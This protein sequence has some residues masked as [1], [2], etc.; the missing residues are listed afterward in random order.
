MKAFSGAGTPADLMIDLSVVSTMYGSEASI[1]EFCGRVTA[2]AAQVTSRYEIVL[3]ND[4]SPD[5]SCAIAHDLAASDPH[6]RVVDLSRNF[7]HHKAMMTGLAYAH[8]QRVFLIDSDLEED[9]AL[10]LAFW[11]QLDALDG[12]DV[13]YGYQTQRRGA[14]FERWTGALF[15]QLFTTATR[16]KVA[17]NLSTVRLMTRRYVDALIRYQESEFFFAGIAETVGFRQVPL[18]ITKLHRSQTTYSIVKKVALAIDAI[19]SFSA[20]PLIFIFLFGI[21]VASLA[22]GFAIFVFL[23]KS[24]SSAPIALGWSSQIFSIWLLGG[25]IISFLGVIGIYLAKIYSEVKRRPFSVVRDVRP[26]ERVQPVDR[27]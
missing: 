15:W 17:R 11:K 14:W 8:G 16:L 2:A 5:R 24:F 25:L 10:L 7:G 9:P 12:V 18:A 4:G 19:T 26:A 1:R 3:V 13:V 22:F 23:R 21:L 20:V 27:D 6:V